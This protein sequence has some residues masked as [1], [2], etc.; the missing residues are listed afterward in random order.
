MVEKAEIR[1]LKNANAL[2][3]RAKRYRENLGLKYV[4]IHPPFCIKVIHDTNHAGKVS[5]YATEAIGVFLAE[6]RRIN[7]D[8]RTCEVS[9]MTETELGGW[10]HPLHTVSR[11]ATRV[12]SSTSRAET[13]GCVTGKELGQ[14]TAQRLTEILFGGILWPNTMVHR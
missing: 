8:P 13:L 6:D 10:L 9:Q 4:P 5:S 14:L 11:K 1:H 3:L 12:S 7:I 2:I